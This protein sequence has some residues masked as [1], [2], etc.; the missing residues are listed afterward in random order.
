MP[1]S[2]TLVG[3]P[4]LCGARRQKCS[5]DAS[6]LGSLKKR[7]Q[8]LHIKSI[9]QCT[10]QSEIQNAN[11]S[12]DPAV[13]LLL[14]A[15]ID[16]PRKLCICRFNTASSATPATAQW[17]SKRRSSPYKQ[18]KSTPMG[19]GLHCNRI[20]KS[21]CCAAVRM[22]LAESSYHPPHPTRI[23]DSACNTET[24][25]P[26]QTTTTFSYL[27]SL[28]S[29]SSPTRPIILSMATPTPVLL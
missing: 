10:P 22:G 24:K 21:Y 28:K 11:R 17:G 12:P 19:D 27:S 26:A 25:W 5:S 8:N 9:D 20:S 16:N 7:C 3:C 13:L 15:E 6:R 14:P 4:G 29:P 1:Q 18:A 2:L 23:T